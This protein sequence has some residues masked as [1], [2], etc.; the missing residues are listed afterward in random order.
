[1]ISHY[2]I[3]YEKLRNSKF[4]RQTL[5]AKPYICTQK[6]DTLGIIPFLNLCVYEHAI[7]WIVRDHFKRTNQEDQ[8]VSS[9]FGKCFEKYF[10]EL[11]SSYLRAD[12]YEKIPE[13]RTRR[14][15][16][17]L[18]ID[19]YGFLVEQKSSLIRLSVKQQEP[20]LDD[21]EYYAK[22][23]LIKAIRQLNR[24]EIDFADGQFFKIILLYDDYLSPEVLEQVFA[25]EECDVQSDDHYWLVTI[26]EME[27]LLGLCQE[28]RDVFDSIIEEKNRREASHSNEGKS[29]LQIMRGKRI[30]ENTF[31]NREA[32]AHYRDF[33]SDQLTKF[34]GKN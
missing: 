29:L 1:M 34:L 28:H 17:K 24:T 26:E 18:R 14:A 5:Y 13:T 15:D 10:E 4:Q 11:L 32:I 3:S 25:M 21:L 19:G 31:L 22:E 23:T 2:S 6:N 20:S 33:A 27:I 9:F 12:E 30:W 16:W 8:R 7:L